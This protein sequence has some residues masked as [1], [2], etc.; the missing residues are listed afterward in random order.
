MLLCLKLI[1][2]GLCKQ[3]AN[4]NKEVNN[5]G[6]TEEDWSKEYENEKE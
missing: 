6:N 4:E 5:K 2:Q 1:N 3:V